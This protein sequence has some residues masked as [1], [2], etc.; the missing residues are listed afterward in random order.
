MSKPIE[1]IATTISG[2]ISDWSKVERVEPLFA[3]HGFTDLRLHVVDTHL[4]AR[5]KALELLG[6]GSRLLISAGGSGTFNAVLEGCC[7]SGLPLGDL[8]LGFLRKGSA[9]LLGKVLGMP[10]EIEAAVAVFAEAIRGGHVMSCDVLQAVND[11]SRGLPRHFV[12]YGGGEIFGRIP[13]FTENRF[14]KWYKGVLSQAFG[15]LGPFTTGMTLALCEKILRGPFGRREWRIEID[16]AEATQGRYQALIIVNGYLGPDMGYS[17]DPLGSGRFHLFA[18]RD[19][20]IG[21][22]LK[23]A[24]KARSGAIMENPERWGMEHYVVGDTLHLTT[25]S[26]RPFPLNVDGSTLICDHAATIRLVDSINL[27]AAPGS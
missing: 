21:R 6:E 4:A 23:Q 17:D 9:D 19:Q 24:G 15:D 25:A 18:L 10:D 12:G 2:S 27:I 8:Q 13:H 5:G 26:E 14:M 3:E 7:D 1:V 11:G 20:G 16:G 22:L